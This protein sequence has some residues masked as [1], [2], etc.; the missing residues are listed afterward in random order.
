[1][2]KH[3]LGAT[4]VAGSI[5]STIL[6][7]GTAYAA[8]DSCNGLS[9]Y[10]GSQT[11]IVVGEDGKTVNVVMVNGARPNAYGTCSG[12]QVMVNFTDDHQVTGTI[13]GDTISWDNNTTWTKAN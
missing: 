12:N 1:M 11:A 7:A 2:K 9:A 5:V 4:L 8:A 13:Q 3:F 10:Y 6:L